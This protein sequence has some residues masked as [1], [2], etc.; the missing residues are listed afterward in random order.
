MFLQFT[1]PPLSEQW[2]TT[3]LQILTTSF[4][5]ALGVVPTLAASLVI[6]ED[7][8][9][10]S[11]Q[12]RFKRWIISIVIVFIFSLLLIWAGPSLLKDSA[13]AERYGVALSYAAL[14]IVAVTPILAAVLGPIIFYGFRRRRIIPRLENTLKKFY[15]KT[16]YLESNTLDDM[17][18]LGEQ[19]NAGAEKAMVIN[20][21]GCL[22]EYVLKSRS[23]K[24]NAL[25]NLIRG[26]EVIITNTEHL[27][28]DSNFEHAA[29]Q[30]K[31]IWLQLTAQGHNNP[32]DAAAVYMTFEKLAISSVGKSSES[33]VLIF[34]EQAAFYGSDIIFAMGVSA[35]SSQRYLAATMALNKL[36]ALAD[37]GKSEL[38]KAQSRL[39]QVRRGIQ[40]D[41]GKKDKALQRE[42]S[43]LK[44]FVEERENSYQEVSAN[45][46]GVLS[47]FTVGGP[48][49]QRR[50][51][52]SL[53]HNKE[54]FL[55]DL[56]TCIERSFSYHYSKSAYKTSDIL[57]QFPEGFLGSV[58]IFSGAR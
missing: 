39:N 1:P 10:V 42:E 45:L 49:T 33:V 14:V 12:L 43:E 51:K 52:I 46:L 58:D 11:H 55:P 50:A 28:N 26:F 25:E 17:I 40:T 15:K 57:A 38:Q 8:R 56:K 44:R 24:D 29:A 48:S 53:E 31:N 5:F 54:L 37:E 47:H 27:G 3:Y 21:L 4:V 9:H 2:A 36:E 35:L 23:Y 41:S 13:V 22:A 18:Y 6:P 19:G 32:K 7:L 20:S 34:L 30:L 16:G